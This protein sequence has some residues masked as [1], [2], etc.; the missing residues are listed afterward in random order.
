MIRNPT[1]DLDR[2][3][4]QL[5]A[6]RQHQ[7]DLEESPENYNSFERPTGAGVQF[8]PEV[9]DRIINVETS[10]VRKKDAA[11]HKELFTRDVVTAFADPIDRGVF[12]QN[13][14]L[15]SHLNTFEEK[16]DSD[17]SNFH[18][19]VVKTIHGVVI[20]SKMTGKACK[21]AKSMY[22]ESTTRLTK[23]LNRPQRR[24]GGLG[25]LLPF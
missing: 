3:E 5:E 2:Y 24:G 8:E 23:E 7:S 1:K 4:E 11:T 19:M 17:L 12:N 6:E 15:L 10:F 13:A 16:Y 18:N 9:S 20:S 25:G 21:V 14:N 22:A